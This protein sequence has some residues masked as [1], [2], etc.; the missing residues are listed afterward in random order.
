[1]KREWNASDTATHSYCSVYRHFWHPAWNASRRSHTNCFTAAGSAS[2]AIRS[3]LNP[4]RV[5]PENY[6]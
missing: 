4:S 2:A 1:M 3:A 5:G 6:L